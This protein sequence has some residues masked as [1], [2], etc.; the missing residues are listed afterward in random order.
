MISFIPTA[1]SAVNVINFR[2]SPK[3]KQMLGKGRSVSKAWPTSEPTIFMTRFHR[4]CITR[5]DLC[6]MGQKVLLWEK[7]GR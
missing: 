7:P 1:P 4:L 2:I 6:H 5:Q 3:G